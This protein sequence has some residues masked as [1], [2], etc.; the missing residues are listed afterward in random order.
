MIAAVRS[1]NNRPRMRTAAPGA[2]R[3]PSDGVPRLITATDRAQLR[4]LTRA[5]YRPS[6]RDLAHAPR[7]NSATDI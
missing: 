3:P 6:N 5:T 2:R 7:C 1:K 4:E